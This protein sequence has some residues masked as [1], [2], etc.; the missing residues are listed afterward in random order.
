M[1]AIAAAFAN[2]DD[3]DV[4]AAVLAAKHHLGLL[5]HMIGNFDTRRGGSLPGKA[6]NKQ[7]DFVSGERGLLRDYFGV[8]GDP[9]V[10]DEKDFTRRF[11]LRHIVFDRVYRELLSEPYFQQRLN[12]KDEPQASTLQKLTAALRVLAF[13]VAYDSADEYVRLSESAVRETVHRFARFVVDK[14]QL[15]YLR[16]PTLSDLQRLLS[17]YE[18]AGFPGCMGCVDCSHWVWKNCPMSLHGQYQA[19]SMK[20][21][22]VM[23][24]VADKD[25]YLWHFYT[26]LPGAMND[27]NVMAFSQLFQT[28]LAGSNPPPIS[29]T[30]NGVERTLPYYLCDGIYAEH[31]VLINTSKGDSEKDK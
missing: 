31:P 26:G 18:K 16:K 23:E 4:A 3:D 22:I 12:A 29:Y 21:S 19:K 20:R 6:P 2:D 30:V 11:R 8:D 17:D 9:P 24:T 14:F 5:D 7:R 10:Y 13:G 1:C 27:L 15:V 25:L 28:M